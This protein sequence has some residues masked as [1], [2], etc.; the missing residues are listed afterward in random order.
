MF[1][2]FA[3]DVFDEFS[4]VARRDRI[5]LH[6][7]FGETDHPDFEAASE[8]DRGTG[9]TRDLDAAAADVDDDGDFA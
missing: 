7:A 6:E 9:S 4:F 1:V 3:F 2:E 8:I 5:A